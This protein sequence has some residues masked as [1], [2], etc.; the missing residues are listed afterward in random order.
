[1][2][3]VVIKIFTKKVFFYDFVKFSPIKWGPKTKLDF[4]Q[5]NL[6]LSNLKPNIQKSSPTPKEKEFMC[7]EE[8]RKGRKLKHIGLFS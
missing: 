7:F 4:K 1:M 3:Y 8:T 5:L 6:I 2:Q